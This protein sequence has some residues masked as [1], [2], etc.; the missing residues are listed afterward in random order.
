MDKIRI[1][2][3][4]DQMSLDVKDIL[5]KCKELNIVARTQSS[6]ITL[7]DANKIKIS[8]IGKPINSNSQKEND[9]VKRSGSRVTIRRKKKEPVKEKPKESEQQEIESKE[10]ESKEIKKVESYDNNDKSERVLKTVDLENVSF[11][12]QVDKSVK[13]EKVEARETP[14]KEE[15][16]KL[17]QL[18]LRK[19][20]Y[21]LQVRMSQSKKRSQKLNL[22]RL[23][24]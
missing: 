10:I 24:L 20:I 1:K 11:N 6:S 9:I 4:A 15:K 5:S 3:L 7:E 23:K 18:I 19:K 8:I 22:L 14:K 16:N 21:R 12:N 17:Q 2:E 13:K